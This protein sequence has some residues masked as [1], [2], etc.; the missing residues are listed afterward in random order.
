MVPMIFF[1]CF[2]F[3]YQSEEGAAQEG[4]LEDMP[5]DPDNEA[6]EMP[7]EVKVY[8][9][10]TVR[11]KFRTS[12]WVFLISSTKNLSLTDFSYVYP[13]NDF[14]SRC[15]SWPNPGHGLGGQLTN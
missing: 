3:K 11:I 13:Q 1:L 10:K 5:V 7:S 15:T 2:P 14:L 4:I 6:Y 9:R 12:S 8:I